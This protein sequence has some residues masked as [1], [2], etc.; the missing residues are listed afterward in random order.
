VWAAS[1]NYSTFYAA[2]TVAGHSFDP[3][4]EQISQQ[5]LTGNTHFL[6]NSPGASAQASEVA[7]LSGWVRSGGTLIL[8]A[9]PDAAWSSPAY[10]N[11]ILSGIGSSISV[12][13][14]TLGSGTPQ[15]H[16][17]LG[18]SDASVMGIQ[19]GGLAAGLV[20]PVMGGTSVAIGGALLPYMVQYQQLDAGKVYVVGGNIAANSVVAQGSNT[21]FLLNLLGQ[22]NGFLNVGEPFADSPE[23]G[24][25][26][27]TAVGLLGAVV[28]ARRRRKQP[29]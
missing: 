15:V 11:G 5:G 16:G 29:E 13:G 3:A 1:G 28:A 24:T 9:N 6:I 2:A 17:I 4:A 19:G 26:A 21:Q 18:G 22:N 7:A 8:V 10:L 23:P 27:L 12:L 25:V 14:Q 20:N